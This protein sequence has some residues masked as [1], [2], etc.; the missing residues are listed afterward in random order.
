MAMNRLREDAVAVVEEYDQD[1]G[2]EEERPE[3]DAGPN[4]QR[5]LAIQTSMRSRRIT[6]NPAGHD[7]VAGLA[8]FGRGWRS[9]LIHIGSTCCFNVAGA[10]SWPCFFSL[11]GGWV[12]CV[13]CG[14]VCSEW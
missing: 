3:L 12:R 10:D 11:S 2:N 5:L 1:E 9:S 14:V 8:L 4:L 13:V 6:Y 7:V